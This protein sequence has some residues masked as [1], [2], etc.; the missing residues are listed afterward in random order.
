M[1]KP[2]KEFHTYKKLTL[3][4]SLLLLVGVVIFFILLMV[5][6]FSGA[7]F[8]G[9]V[10]TGLI[11]LAICV[12]ASVFVFK[13]RKYYCPRCGCRYVETGNYRD[14]GDMEI[15]SGQYSTTVYEWLHVE[16]ECPICE[17]TKIIA[18]KHKIGRY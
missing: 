2:K 4:A 17:T 3:L 5:G 7:D 12:V 11:I 16:Y 1:N 9:L 10:V 15:S 14:T 18:E 6:Q 13:K 8:M